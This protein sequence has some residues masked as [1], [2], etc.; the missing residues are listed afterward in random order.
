MSIVNDRKHINTADSINIADSQDIYFA[1]R[2][3]VI[4]GSLRLIL[5]EMLGTLCKIL[6]QSE[7]NDDISLTK[8]TN[9][10]ENC[11]SITIEYSP[12]SICVNDIKNDNS[13][14][15]EVTRGAIAIYQNKGDMMSKIFVFH[16]EQQE[17]IQK[18]ISNKYVDDDKVARLN[19]IASRTH[20]AVVL[21]QLDKNSTNNI[22]KLSN[23][24]NRNII[25]EIFKEAKHKN[26][27]TNSP[28]KDMVVAANNVAKYISNEI[29]TDKNNVIILLPSSRGINIS[30][31]CDMSKNANIDYINRAKP[32][33]LHIDG[34]LI[35]VNRNDIKNNAEKIYHGYNDDIKREYNGKIYGGD[36][37]DII[38]EYDDFKRKYGNE[39]NDITKKYSDDFKK[40]SGNFFDD[41]KKTVTDSGVNQGQLDKGY[42]TIK[43]KVEGTVEGTYD[44]GFD[45]IKQK[46]EGT[47]N[48]GY[49]TITRK[50]E[51]TIEG[52]LKR[53]AESTLKGTLEGAVNQVKSWFGKLGQFGGSIVPASKY[54]YVV[55]QGH[56]IDNSTAHKISRNGDMFRMQAHRRASQDRSPRNYN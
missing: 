34:V 25:S 33:M 20:G 9:C 8:Y 50:V 13:N 45:T 2:E 46:V 39:I 19:D 4:K 37:N 28:K 42:D 7:I 38:N 48:K 35:P 53:G 32:M 22:R 47:Y 24:A 18:Y 36:F 44:K 16:I 6:N 56:N 55:K 43:Q 29:M 23:T 15:C 12:N 10:G 41:I 27:S 49:D 51:D 11:K 54:L 3:R 17:L 1:S 30:N 40:S 52:D 31:K 5:V 21:D 14:S 26:L